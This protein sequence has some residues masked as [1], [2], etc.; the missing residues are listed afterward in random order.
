MQ[1]EASTEIFP[2]LPSFHTSREKKQ[3]EDH[4]EWHFFTDRRPIISKT[5]GCE[6]FDNI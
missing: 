6:A 5:K 4:V 2:V 1:L 3:P